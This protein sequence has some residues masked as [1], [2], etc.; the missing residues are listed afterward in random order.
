M[1]AWTWPIIF[2]GLAP[3]LLALDT[4]RTLRGAAASALVLCVV[5]VAAIFA[6]F[7]FSIAVYSA[8]NAA[9]GLTALL[10]CAPLLQ[11]QFLPFALARHLAGRW[12]GRVLQA[13]AGACG[14]VAAEWL[15][16]KLL[17]DTLAHGLYPSAVLRQ[18]A[19]LGGTAGVTLALVVVNECVAAAIAGQTRGRRAMLAP[20]AIGAGI[21]VA[22]SVYGA[23]RLSSLSS[24]TMQ[25]KPVRVG[26]IQ[27]NIAGYERLGREMGKYE[28][29]QY[30]LDTHYTMSQQAID[31]GRLDA[32]L[33]S[34]TVYPTTFGRPK[35]E[36]GA[37][38]DVELARFVTRAGLP[39]VFGTYDS[40]EGGEYNAAVFLE[41]ALPGAAPRFDLYRKIHLFL[42]TE[43][44]PSWLEWPTIRQWLPWAGT[45][46]PGS[47]VRVLPLRLA[48]GREIPVLPM[49]CLDDVVTEMGIQGAR[50]GA[51]LI[52]TMSNDSWF[53]EHPDGARLHLAVAAFRTIETRLPQLRVTANGISAV[54]DR[55]GAITAGAGMGERTWI[56]G[57]A[58]T[59]AP[60]A[61][62]LVAWGNW[63]GPVSLVALL[64][65]LGV[66]Y[67]T[68]RPRVADP[69][70]AR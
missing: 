48:D 27:S 18:T 10:V 28:A 15:F 16:P 22:M 12:H 35:S 6:W 9:A 60:P 53:T 17:G 66:P 23:A 55:T 47:V 4:V 43:Y 63:P 69:G 70:R 32:L 14:Y 61:T 36:G 5:F 67:L 13:V 1:Q 29:V 34:E 57:E 26:M 51:R 38:L 8:G 56:V 31:S 58:S 64:L 41:P 59:S 50:L 62:L 65:L 19:D 52:F 40:D 24:Q 49:I 20:L 44:M 7:G 30:V 42:F 39:L 25:E 3:W 11:P 33:W 21:V 45:W 37:E 46:K 68:R 2:F 54:F